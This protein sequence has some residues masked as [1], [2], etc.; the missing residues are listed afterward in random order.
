M[1][2]STFLHLSGLG[3]WTETQLW[4]LGIRDWA[5]FRRRS[6]LPGVS[7]ERKAR[8]DRE[9][10]LGERALSER[11]ADW[12]ARRLPSAE[13]WRLDPEFR[14]EIAF[15][16]IETTALSPYQGIVTV[17]AVHGG[18]RTRSFVAGEDLEE[19]PAYL[20]Q[21]RALVTFNGIFFDV[22]FLRVAFPHWIPPAAH[23]DLRFV[24]RRLGY[25]GGLKRIEQELRLGE[26]EGV[27]GLRGLDAVRLWQEWRRGRRESLDLLIEYN[28]ADTVNLEPLLEFS[29][30]EMARRLRPARPDPPVESY[31]TGIIPH[32]PGPTPGDPV[33]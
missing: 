20:G 14:A 2:R 3:P 31:G 5:E 6:S 21:F 12:F 10:D 23:I 29:V 24:L 9:L 25:S 11:A 28:R 27:E 16:D 30:A 8:W 19:L 15:L 7:P 32:R 22:P 13:H 1:L 4:K 18:G 26:R 17:V 33:A